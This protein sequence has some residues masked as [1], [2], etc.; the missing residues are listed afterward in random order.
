M[1]GFIVFI[2]SRTLFVIFCFRSQRRVS[3]A[4]NFVFSDHA[5]KIVGRVS[6]NFPTFFFAGFFFPLLFIFRH[7]PLNI[8]AISGTISFA[9][10]KDTKNLK[11]LFEINQPIVPSS[12]VSFVLNPTPTHTTGLK[13]GF[14]F[15]D[16]KNS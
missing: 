2:K 12:Q 11:I 8:R 14:C 4:K 5:K 10:V 16:L 1:L 7:F 3:L 15:L 9:P 6:S 13:S